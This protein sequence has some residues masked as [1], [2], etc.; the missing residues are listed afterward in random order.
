MENLEWP[1][2]TWVREIL[3]GVAECH[4]G[5][6]AYD[7]EQE[8]R[9]FTDGPHSSVPAEESFRELSSK[10]TKNHTI[11]RVSRWHHLLNSTVIEDYDRRK[12]PVTAASR[13][14][15]MDARLITDKLFESGSQVFSLG[16]EE[17]DRFTEALVCVMV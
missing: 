10:S 14:V 7:L 15:S 12:P 8:V 17:L 1:L 9:E 3:V 2:N 4:G 13:S 6:F 16:E 5:P 11:S